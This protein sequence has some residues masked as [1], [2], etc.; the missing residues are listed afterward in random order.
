MV[1]LGV[2]R[3]L[4]HSLLREAQRLRSAFGYCDTAVARGCRRRPLRRLLV[5]GGCGAHCRSFIGRLLYDDETGDTVDY[6][7]ALDGPRGPGVLSVCAR[8]SSIQV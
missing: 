1:Q 5:C 7:V 8:A 2:Q 6:E 4:W 3:S